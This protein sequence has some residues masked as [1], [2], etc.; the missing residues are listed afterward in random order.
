M[1]KLHGIRALAF[2]AY[3]TVF[4]V[5]SVVTLAETM[6][7]GKGKELSQLWRSK[8]I[9]YMFL[10]TIMGRYIPHDQNTEAGLT[11]SM[12][13]LGLPGGASERKALMDAYEKLSPFDDARKTLPKLNGIKK[14]ILSVGT[15][16]LL[17]NLVGNAGIASQFDA[18]LSVDE[19]KVYKPHPRTYQLATDKFNLQRH[20]IGFVTSN[21][22]DVAGA[23]AFG[24]Q[25]IWI[26]RNSALPDELGLLPDIEL[27]SIENIPEILS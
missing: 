19:V 9:E 7:P 4:D 15:P 21:Y 16:S 23:K 3:G 24:F 22:F 5:H 6:F 1:K 17:T 27:N 18:L 12:K 25:V 10:R 8:Q 13:Y 20:E 26:N 2:D 14:A 11:Y